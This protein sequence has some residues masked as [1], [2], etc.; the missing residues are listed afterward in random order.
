MVS[1]ILTAATVLAP[2]AG[3]QATP[4][5]PE[6]Q[7]CASDRA[8]PPPPVDTSEVPKP[9]QK[10]PEPLPVPATPVGG[11]RMGECGLVLPRGAGEPP[12]VI[13]SASWVIQ[14]LDTGAILAAKDPHARQRPASLIKVLLALVAVNE[15]DPKRM[16]TASAE[17]AS[18]ECTCVGLVAGGQYTVEQLLQ[19]TLMHS[20]NDTAHALATTLGG[21]P[22]TLEKMN[23][24]AERIG[25]M[26]TRAAT[27]SGLDGP[28]MSSSAYDLSLIFHYAMKQ[29]V[30]AKAVATRQMQ[31]PGWGD[32][33]SFPLYNDNKLLSIYDGFLGGKT[34]FT[35]DARHTYLGG[36]ERKGKRLAV[37]TMRGEQKPMRVSDQAGK[38]LDYGFELAASKPEPVGQ[39]TYREGGLQ[40]GGNPQAGPDLGEDPAKSAAAMSQEDPFG[41]TGWI[42]T[43]V[44]AVIIIAG[45]VVGH[46]R[47]RAA[48]LAE[49]TDVLPRIRD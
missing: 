43:L 4:R 5:A 48:L 30:F 16:V 23:S 3:A 33:P 22:A 26:D 25:A 37:V 24:A 39:I 29:P 42:I 45:F 6:K 28:G 13:N 7:S 36:A 8:V 41:T 14:D 20:G 32:K 9:G 19:G 47:K 46:R 10:A 17:D 15:L 49:Q 34:G 18:Q 35:D 38:L 21:V 1:A 11:D 40:P 2:A 44:V 12:A 31:F 27:P